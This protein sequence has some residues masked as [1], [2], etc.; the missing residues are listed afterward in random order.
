[1]GVVCFGGSRV[2][3]QVAVRYVGQILFMCDA[4]EKKRM[5]V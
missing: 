5:R 2:V 4:G 3:I 1:M